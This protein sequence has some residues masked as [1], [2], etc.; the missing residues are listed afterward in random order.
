MAGVGAPVTL[1]VN[2]A[3]PPT[4]TVLFAGCPVTVGVVAT[5]TV[6]TMPGWIV[7]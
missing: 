6:P 2:R 7:Q 1:A 5:V 4:T 3:V